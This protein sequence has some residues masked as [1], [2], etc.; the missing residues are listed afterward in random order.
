MAYKLY[1]EFFAGHIRA[2]ADEAGQGW[3][4]GEVDASPLWQGP[5]VAFPCMADC[6]RFKHAHTQE[7]LV[8]IVVVRT[9]VGVGV[10]GHIT[11]FSFVARWRVGCSTAVA[12]WGG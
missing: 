12:G 8:D 2:D 10:G 1:N 7:Q 11:P 9:W 3:A 6:I 4:G 5:P